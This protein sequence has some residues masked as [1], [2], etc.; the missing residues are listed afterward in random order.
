MKTCRDCGQAKPAT[1]F[2]GRHT[3][4]KPCV[5]LRASRWRKAN[6]ERYKALCNKKRGERRWDSMREMVLSTIVDLQDRVQ[7]LEL[8]IRNLRRD[9]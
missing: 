4:C 2:Y 7:A 6:P 8:Q 5:I 9:R 3:A 1:E